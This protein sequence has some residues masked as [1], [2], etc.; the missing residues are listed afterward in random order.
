MLTQITTGTSE[1]A[2]GGV[3]ADSR[4]CKAVPATSAWPKEEAGEETVRSEGAKAEEG[5]YEEGRSEGGEKEECLM[6]AR[7]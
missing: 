6:S 2:T 3:A 1:H 7:D 4:S 5:H